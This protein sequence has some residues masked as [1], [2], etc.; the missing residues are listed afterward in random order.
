[1]SASHWYKHSLL[2]HFEYVRRPRRH[3]SASRPGAVE[4]AFGPYL[5][6]T[7]ESARHLWIASIS[8]VRSPRRS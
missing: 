1:M 6:L 7:S 2:I 5:D 4:R 8:S 3:I